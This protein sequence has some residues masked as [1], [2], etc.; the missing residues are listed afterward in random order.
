[1]SRQARPFALGLIIAA[2]VGLAVLVGLGR[3]FP[4][5]PEPAPAPWER[6]AGE[7]DILRDRLRVHAGA[8]RL[9]VP[10]PPGTRVSFG[11]APGDRPAVVEVGD[12]LR[13]EITASARIELRAR[14]ETVEL[15]ADGR[16]LRSGPAGRLVVSTPGTAVVDDLRVEAVE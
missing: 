13:A 5:P 15:R 8:A 1:M 12:A 9:C 6:V 14:E 2:V 16:L 11:L 4:A 10:F 3:P 7:V